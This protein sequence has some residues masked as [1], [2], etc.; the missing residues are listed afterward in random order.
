MRVTDTTGTSAGAVFETLLQ[1]YLPQ[2]GGT[3]TVVCRDATLKAFETE[4][5]ELQ[6][7]L[8]RSAAAHDYVLVIRSGLR[9]AAKVACHEFAHLLQY[10]SG[11][12]SLD[13]AAGTFSWQGCIYGPEYPYESRPWESEAFFREREFYKYYRRSNA[14]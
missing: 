11:D 13:I 3:V 1:H 8:H 9:N 4:G 7:L 6:A 12:L 10:E 14:I 5:M 2:F